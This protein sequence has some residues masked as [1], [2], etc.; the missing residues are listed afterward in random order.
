MAITINTATAR[1]T[2]RDR[3]CQ[4]RKP[5]L[6]ALDADWFRA[7]ETEDAI[8]K[9]AIAAQ[10]QTLRDITEDPR[11]DAAATPEALSVLTLEVLTA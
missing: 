11:I 8:E 7:A 5:L 1:D 4:A 2:H 3:P 10:K 9:A 6:D